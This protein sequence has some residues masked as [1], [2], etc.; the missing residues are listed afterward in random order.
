MVRYQYKNKK[1]LF[2]GE[3]LQSSFTAHAE[4]AQPPTL[5]FSVF[6]A[7]AQTVPVSVCCGS[8]KLRGY[9]NK[10]LLNGAKAESS[11]AG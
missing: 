2:V 11:P 7:T 4:D 1:F 3:N 6:G 9:S 8:F 10:L 5:L